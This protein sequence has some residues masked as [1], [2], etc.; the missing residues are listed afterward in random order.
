MNTKTKIG[1]ITAVPI[2]TALVLVM[3]II[4]AIKR[5]ILWIFDLIGTLDGL[6]YLA[7]KSGAKVTAMKRE[8]KTK[9]E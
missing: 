6:I 8:F 7:K 2:F 4:I 5:V 9:A 3:V 1:L